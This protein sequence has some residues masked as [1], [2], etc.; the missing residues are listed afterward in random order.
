MKLYQNLANSVQVIGNFLSTS[1]TSVKRSTCNTH[2][3]FLDGDV[4]QMH[5]HV[6]QFSHTRVVFDGAEPTETETISGERYNNM[7]C[8]AVV[9]CVL[10]PRKHM[11]G[12]SWES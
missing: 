8:N 2:A 12:R 11:R 4:G 7:I 6:V 1:Q 10:L 5:E 3:I 9:T